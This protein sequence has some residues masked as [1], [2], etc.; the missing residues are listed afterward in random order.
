M[1]TMIGFIV[2]VALS[3]QLAPTLTGRDIFFGVTV[4][5]GFRDGSL[6]RSVSRRYAIEIWLLA[7]IAGLL[8]VT[9]PLPVVSA[10]M[11]L[12]Q[13]LGAFVAFARARSDVRPH[14]VMPAA[15]REA[16]LGPRSPLPG[17]LI[18]Q[19]GPFLILLAA[20]AYVG[21]N[22]Q[23]VPARFP[24]HW[25][26]AGKANGW[27]AKSIA[28]VFR[29]LEI[30]F[31]G[32]AMLCFTSYAVLHWSRLPRVTGE[33]GRQHHRV[34]QANLV[35]I[36]AS[37]YL[38]AL[39][40]AWTTVMAMFSDNAGQLRLPL[41]FRIAPFALVI[42]G[43]LVVR[44]LR[45]TAVPASSPVADTTPDSSWAFGRIYFNRNDPALFV[46]RRMGLGYTL[47]LGNPWSWLV[48]IV[49]AIAISVPLLLV[50]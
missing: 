45:R 44:L 9:A 18:A 20:A 50:P 15:T 34:R 24:T 27:T 28:G 3:S 11:L 29:G 16:E 32:C 6:A 33:E 23:D 13:T 30:G 5:A 1:E 21:F 39:L 22:W 46:E 48:V 7:I 38:L 17:G 36:L 47:N 37:E 31:I 40:M 49:F 10:P 12:A 41:A 4:P 26:L 42:T 25:N 43:T 19:L 2:L 8:V 14:A 35:A